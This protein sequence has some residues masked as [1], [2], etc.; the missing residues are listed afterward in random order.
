MVGVLTMDEYHPLRILAGI[1][2]H[3]LY[4]NIECILHN[5]S[6]DASVPGAEL[7]KAA[8]NDTR[9]A[10]RIAYGF[11]GFDQW[12]LNEIIYDLSAAVPNLN[13]TR[14]S[15]PATRAFGTNA[16]V[17]LGDRAPGAYQ[18]FYFL[19]NNPASYHAAYLPAEMLHSGFDPQTDFECSL[20]LVPHSIKLHQADQTAEDI[21]ILFRDSPRIEFDLD[22]TDADDFRERLQA[23]S[24]LDSETAQRFGYLVMQSLHHICCTRHSATQIP[25]ANDALGQI[26]PII[27]FPQQ[28][29]DE[30]LADKPL[31]SELIAQIS[32]D[33]ARRYPN[34]FKDVGDSADFSAYAEGRIRMV[35]QMA[36]HE[37]P[38]RQA[39]LKILT[40]LKL[41]TEILPFARSCQRWLRQHENGFRI[42]RKGRTFHFATGPGD[43]L[44][45]SDDMLDQD[46]L[47]IAIEHNLIRITETPQHETT[48][49]LT[50][51]GLDIIHSI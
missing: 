9:A 45:V 24:D 48:Y 30:L 38:K 22:N 29:A 28:P 33:L 32:L 26:K 50:D 44:T 27:V 6:L 16:Y 11:H 35:V 2:K 51:L 3:S 25:I 1:R 47:A 19:I 31:S 23:A 40:D 12:Q 39:E 5:P 8:N 43:L 46:Q 37:G 20:V 4:A 34:G 21:A 13:L 7:L 15:P 42:I 49:E 10:A 14:F 18:G 36:L 17:H 41:H